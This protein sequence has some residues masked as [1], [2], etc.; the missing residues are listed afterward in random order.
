MDRQPKTQPICGLW[1]SPQAK[2]HVAHADGEGR[3]EASS[4]FHPFVWTSAA[5]DTDAYGCKRIP[6]DGPAGAPLDCVVRF[7]DAKNYES[8]SK[9]RDRNLPFLRLSSLENQFLMRNG[10]RMFE[11]VKFENIRRMQLDIETHSEVGFPNPSKRSDRI[12]AI[13]L[14]SDGFEKLIEIEELTDE[15]EKKL[16]EK[17]CKELVK[18]DPDVIEGHNIFDFDLQYIAKRCSMLKCEFKIGR[19]GAPPSFRKSRIKIAERTLDYVR[20]DI[21]GRT[22]ADTLLLVQLYDISRREMPSYSL[23]AAALHFGI[24][25][26]GERTYIKG[27]EI[28]DIFVSDRKKF[29]AYLSDDL[30]ETRELAAV[31]LPTYVAQVQNF[32]M[33]LQECMLRG[34]GMKVEYVFLEKYFHAKAKLPEIPPSH[35]FSG[36]ISESYETGVFKRVLHYD[37]ASLYPSIMMHI[38]K[39]P[40][41]D[42]LKVFL[43]VL[44]E[45]R[46]YRLKYKLLAKT[47][48][49]AEEKRE[50][51]ARQ[52]SFKILIN[53]FYGYLGL[54]TARFG[55]SDLAE[56]ITAMGRE[57]LTALMDKFRALKCKVLEADT[58]GIYLS[59]E[60]YFD[61]PEALLEKVR[62]VLPAGIELEF[63][64]AYEAM[65][66][67]KAKNYA[68]IEDGELRLK[69]S[70]LRNRGTEPYLAR[71]SNAIIEIELGLSKE[72]LAELIL[73]EKAKIESGKYDV[74]ELAKSEYLAQSP[75]AYEAAVAQTGKG[76]RAALEA[77]LMLKPQP[78]AGEKVSF[79]IIKGEKKQR[80]WQRARPAELYDPENF[81]Y[82]AEY[83]VEKLKDI[84]E[85]F[86]SV[87]GGF[88]FPE[89]AAKENGGGQGELF[90]F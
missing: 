80:D 5:A 24:S 57:I 16:L 51:D 43:D 45:L 8:F 13:G 76:R 42:Y 34:T 47:A 48:H 53:S 64:G 58:D 81:P 17:F 28:K 31:L 50:Y 40:Q 14:S 85:R 75:S 7:A 60:D 68:L 54:A 69:G 19:F 23:K 26:S 4:D 77:A 63:D 66:C 37:V 52:N 9:N 55:D 73:S 10:Q 11:G 30:R 70:A 49:S 72:S 79:Y 89:S 35:V 74:R 71:I 83:Y 6:L 61:N 78:K 59:A 12:I 90:D 44:K 84:C 29:R 86:E 3:L 33:T 87:T 56:E 65:L 62:E 27:D 32:P 22:V 39:C 25:K 82:D 15:A 2:T 67:Y 46:E 36:A 41:A 21:P 18:F 20:C 88:K 1:V 38:G